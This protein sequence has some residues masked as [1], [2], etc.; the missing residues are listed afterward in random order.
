MNKALSTWSTEPPPMEFWV[1][2]QGL[3]EYEQ[4]EQH[5]W[6]TGADRPMWRFRWL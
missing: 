1:G 3:Q 6:P 2:K 5:V 4:E